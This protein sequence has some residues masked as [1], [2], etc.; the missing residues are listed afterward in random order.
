MIVFFTWFVSYSLVQ[1]MHVIS[2]NPRYGTE[3]ED[4]YITTNFVVNEENMIKNN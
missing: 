1:S 3:V 4:C 2:G